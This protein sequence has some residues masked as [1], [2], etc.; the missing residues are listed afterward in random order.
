MK[1]KSVINLKAGSNYFRQISVIILALLLTIIT[2]QA[3]SAD[4]YVTP[5]SAYVTSSGLNI[6]SGPGMGFSQIG[7]LRHSERVRII[8]HSGS[9]RKIQRGSSAAYVSG[10]YL[11]LTPGSS[12]PSPHFGGPTTVIEQ[13]VDNGPVVNTSN[14]LNVSDY[15]ANVSAS[16]LNVRK[17]PGTQYGIH[18]S[19]PYNYTVKVTHHQGLW[20]RI[21]WSS[22]LAYVHGNYLRRNSVIEGVAD[23][24]GLQ[25]Q[26]GNNNPGSENLL[27]LPS[28]L[29]NWQSPSSY[30]G[31]YFVRAF[32]RSEMRGQPHT[33]CPAGSRY[34]EAGGT[35][36]VIAE[37]G[38][39]VYLQNIATEYYGWVY[40]TSLILI[41]DTNESTCNDD[42]PT[43][44]ERLSAPY[45]IAAKEDSVMHSSPG[46]T[47]NTDNHRF[48]KGENGSAQAERGD[49]VFIL[50]N[51][52]DQTGWI[53]KDKLLYGHSPEP[54]PR[55][56][57]RIVNTVVELGCIVFSTVTAL[58][59]TKF[60]DFA[61]SMTSNLA[62]GNSFASSREVQRNCLV[63][64]G[65]TVSGCPWVNQQPYKSNVDAWLALPN[66]RNGNVNAVDGRV[67]SANDAYINCL[68]A[69][70]NFGPDHW[71]LGWN[72]GGCVAEYRDKP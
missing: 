46:V 65:I 7:I 64:A 68:W 26:P 3:Q 38:D 17:G 58:P 1:T 9:W 33:G 60:V 18:R 34:L 42:N 39:W 10:N 55:I 41:E 37:Q 56:D 63:E 27:P 43:D 50:N 8:A 6:R 36:R 53:H 19:I 5:Y 20:L 66:T 16:A 72:H 67:L 45:L 24:E 51:F 52:N 71:S 4:S 22:G 70:A 49:W 30:I 21:E 47:C 48:R 29:C 62:C 23:P 15:H 11:T 28:V 40:K 32:S 57:N 61:L 12:R 14:D 59:P 13:P 31:N 35:A 69:A 54:E 44:T 25:P 2:Q